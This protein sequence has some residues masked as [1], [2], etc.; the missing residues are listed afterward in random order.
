MIMSKGAVLNTMNKQA[1]VFFKSAQLIL[2][3]EWRNVE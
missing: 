1:P 2:E 3:A